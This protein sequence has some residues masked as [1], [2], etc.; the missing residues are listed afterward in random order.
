MQ[1]LWILIRCESYFIDT[2]IIL[3]LWKFYTKIPALTSCIQGGLKLISSSGT[4]QVGLLF[5]HSLIHISLSIGIE[6]GT[7][8]FKINRQTCIYINEKQD[9]QSL[10]I[11]QAQNIKITTSSHMFCLFVVVLPD[12][13]SFTHQR[14]PHNW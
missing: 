10:N 5:A 1:I 8:T 14:H 11:M 2:A 3:H 9:T 6:I 4:G 7:F 13:E 12:K